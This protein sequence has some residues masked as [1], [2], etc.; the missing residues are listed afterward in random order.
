M[1]I[2]EVKFD[3]EELLSNKPPEPKF[4]SPFARRDCDC[5]DCADIIKNDAYRMWEDNNH[6]ENEEQL[7]EAVSKF[8]WGD[9]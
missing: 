6:I 5:A 2:G 7:A 8:N 9:E 4:Q 1:K 3:L